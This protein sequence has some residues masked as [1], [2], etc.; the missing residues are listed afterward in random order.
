[1]LIVDE[2]KLQLGDLRCV[3]TI[4][5]NV[6]SL[7]VFFEIFWFGI[8]TGRK[9]TFATQDIEETCD[10]CFFLTSIDFQP[11]ISN[12]WKHLRNFPLLV[13]KQKVTPLLVHAL[14]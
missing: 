10:E 3:W 8:G 11:L 1:M 14:I 4:A 9:V 2:C 5:I 12:V 7:A 6:D 13:P